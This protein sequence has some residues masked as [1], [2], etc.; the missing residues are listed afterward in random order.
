VTLTSG[1]D[2][3]PLL[4]LEALVGRREGTSQ[5]PMVEIVDVHKSF[6][7]TEV[8]KGIDLSVAPGEVV[9]IV[10]PSG[11][12]KSTL[13]RLVNFLEVPERLS[14]TNPVL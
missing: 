8:L 4:G 11:S 6:G 7:S 1:T 9:C 5:G 10:G 13:L 12:G 14:L 2:E 3:A